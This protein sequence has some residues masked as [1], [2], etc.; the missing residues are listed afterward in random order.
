MVEVDGSLVFLSSK[1]Q[2]SHHLS[3][4]HDAG[5]AACMGATGRLWWEGGTGKE[6]R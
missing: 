6:G 2:V 1:H 5:I 4:S 3:N